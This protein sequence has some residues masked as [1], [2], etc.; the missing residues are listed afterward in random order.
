MHCLLCL[1]NHYCCWFIAKLKKI[2]YSFYSRIIFRLNFNS[3]DI[4]LIV[5][6]KRREL[7]YVEAHYPSIYRL[8]KG[9]RSF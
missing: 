2:I 9:Y 8:G 1:A 4:D 5:S 6:T 3:I 7:E